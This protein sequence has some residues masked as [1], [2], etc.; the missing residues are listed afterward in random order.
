MQVI[1]DASK[2]QPIDEEG[3]KVQP[4]N[5]YG[6]LLHVKCSD[7]IHSMTYQPIIIIIAGTTYFLVDLVFLKKGV[8]SRAFGML[9]LIIGLVVSIVFIAMGINASTDRTNKVRDDY[10]LTFTIC[11]ILSSDHLQNRYHS[12]PSE[13]FIEEQ[14]QK[15]L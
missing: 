12:K 15:I 4:L 2:V 14:T 11:A 7:K 8:K 1:F 10:F 5:Y 3:F 13:I 9:L 6:F